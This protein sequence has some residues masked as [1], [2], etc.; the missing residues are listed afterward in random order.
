MTALSLAVASGWQERV[1]DLL[2]AC[3]DTELHYF[4]T[5]ETALHLA[6]E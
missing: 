1:E 5:G 2:Q 6:V 3:A 4:R